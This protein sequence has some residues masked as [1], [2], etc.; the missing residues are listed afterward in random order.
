MISIIIP[1]KDEP[2]LQNLIEQIH[3]NVKERHEIIVVDKSKTTPSIKGAKVILQKS[4]SLGNAVFEGFECSKGDKIVVM[5][6]DGSHQPKD[7][8]KLV[9]WLD[10]YNIVLGM[11]KSEMSLFRRVISKI[12]GW[13]VRIFFNVQVKDILSGFVAARR[14]VF[15]SIG[16]PN[17]TIGFKFVLLLIDRTNSVKEIP[18]IHPDRKAGRSKAKIKEIYRLFRVIWNIKI[19]GVKKFLLHSRFYKKFRGVIV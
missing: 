4:D 16:I 6:A 11:R 19:K 12:S 2:Y 9:K 1:S 14:E 10:K 18:V 13:F 15:K 7:I 8:Q 17:Y 5:D 3:I